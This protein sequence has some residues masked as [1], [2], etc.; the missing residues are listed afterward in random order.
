[1]Y[2][3]K[4]AY[5]EIVSNACISC[6]DKKNN[7]VDKEKLAKIV[8]PFENRGDF[9]GKEN[10]QRYFRVPL[11]RNVVKTYPYFHNGGIEELEDAIKLMVEH[12]HRTKISDDEVK[13]IVSFLKAVDG[14]VVE[15]VNN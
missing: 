15:Y 12:Q 4:I 13:K 14:D 2:P 8:F 10:P 11:L 1:M 9:L 3:E 7:K 5:K 6:H